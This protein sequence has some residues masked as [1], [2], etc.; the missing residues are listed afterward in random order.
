MTCTCQIDVDPEVYLQV[1]SEKIVTAR[2]PHKCNE[3]SDIIELGQQYERL[4]GN[5]D[6]HFLVHKTCFD[7][8]SVRNTLFCTWHIGRIWDD[9]WDDIYYTDGREAIANCLSELTPKAREK[10]CALL[11][12]VWESGKI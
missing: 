6:G 8:L 9:L 12:D 3:C 4:A 2:I 5:D 11:E 7:C 1:I 10:V